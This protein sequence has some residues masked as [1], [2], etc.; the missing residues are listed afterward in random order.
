MGKIS[1]TFLYIILS[2]GAIA[3]LG[4]RAATIDGGY[5]SVSVPDLRQ[6][7]SFFQGVLDCDLITPEP[8]SGEVTPVSLLLSCDQ[9]SVVELF[10]DG[11][12]SPSLA[13]NGMAQPLQFVSDN[14]LRA[15]QWLQQQGGMVSGAP[16]R[17]TSGPLAG[18]VVLDFTAPW[19]LR[20]QLL[21]RDTR[22]PHGG[23]V[24]TTRAQPDGG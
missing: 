6:A 16:H 20:L 18:R 4:A 23:T 8:A 14:V 5:V 1:L 11:D 17:V 10:L 22:E 7:A 9:G 24:A 12:K 2:L 19:G 3:S 15:G 21:G 13:S